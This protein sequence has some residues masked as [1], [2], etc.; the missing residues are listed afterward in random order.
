M[1]KRDFGILLL[2]VFAIYYALQHEGTFQFQKEW[3]VCAWHGRCPWR[4][5][6]AHANG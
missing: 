3:C 5:L 1:Y 6:G 2:S 4:G